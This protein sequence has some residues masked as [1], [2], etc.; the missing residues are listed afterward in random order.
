MSIQGLCRAAA[1]FLAKLQPNSDPAGV[2]QLQL[3]PL[4][5]AGWINRHQQNALEYLQEEVKV[6]K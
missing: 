1:E 4:W 3:F 5:L 6:L 2:N